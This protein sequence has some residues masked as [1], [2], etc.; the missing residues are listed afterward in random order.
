MGAEYGF[1]DSGWAIQEAD[2]DADP[3]DLPLISYNT[4]NTYFFFNQDHSFIYANLD[5]EDFSATGFIRISTCAMIIRGCLC[6]ITTNSPVMYLENASVLLGRCVFTGDGIGGTSQRGIYA[7][8]G[9]GI[10]L[11]DV[12]LYG[13]QDNG[14][15]CADGGTVY[16]ENVNIGVEEANGDDDFYIAGPCQVYGRDVKLGGTN[17]EVLFFDRTF[18]GRITLENYQKILGA[19]YQLVPQGI[20]TKVDV[21]AGSGD[22]EPFKRSGGADS[23][24]EILFNATGAGYKGKAKNPPHNQVIFEHEFEATTATKNYR[25]YV[26]AEGIVDADELWIEVEYVLQYEDDS[27]YTYTKVESVES[28][29][30]A[31]DFEDWAEYMEVTGITP[32][33]GSKV[34][35]KCY[36]RYYDATNKIFID[37]KVVITDG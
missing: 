24:M 2:W 37:P 6:H 16:L 7:R 13:F 18:G 11:K 33:V 28:F 25:Y 22:P 15:H 23:V 4:A 29:T 31:A 19:H 21:V 36:C 5:H 12:A 10:M 1:D 14:M 17:D 8:S 35:I 9:Q 30:A 3:D 34:R 27:E 20:I 32:A 26:Q